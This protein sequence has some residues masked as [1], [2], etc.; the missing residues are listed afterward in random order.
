MT[1]C[2]FRMDVSFL[3]LLIYTLRKQ[4]KLI[5]GTKES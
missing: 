3:A 5:D 1:E 2:R 4:G